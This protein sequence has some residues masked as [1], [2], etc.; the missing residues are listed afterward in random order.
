MKCIKLF[1]FVQV[2]VQWW[3]YE[4]GPLV[5]PPEDQAPAGDQHTTNPPC[6]IFAYHK[7]TI[8]YICELC[9]GT[10]PITAYLFLS[11]RSTPSSETRERNNNQPHIVLFINDDGNLRQCFIS[12]R[13]W[14]KSRSLKLLTWSQ[15][16]SSVLHP[17]VHE[18]SALSQKGFV[19]GKMLQLPRSMRQRRQLPPRNLVLLKINVVYSRF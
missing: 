5:L 12:V 17:I 6:Y 10:W 11:Q 14:N 7:S 8:L 18:Q 4:F 16:C 19:Q 3:E 13:I 15:Q 2:I 9:T 1:C